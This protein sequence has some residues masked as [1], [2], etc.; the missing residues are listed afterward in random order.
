M[1]SLVPP[2][3]QHVFGDRPEGTPPLLVDSDETRRPEDDHRPVVQGVME[4][5]TGRDDP[6]DDR[7]R[8]AHRC[9]TSDEPQHAAR[10][11]SV[12]VE[13]IVD[14][15]MN[16]RN[17]DR[18]IVGDEPDV[19]DQR[20]I[21]DL[22]DRLSVVMA[23]FGMATDAS[24]VH[25]ARLPGMIVVAHAAPRCQTSTRRPYSSLDSMS[26]SWRPSAMIV[27]SATITTRSAR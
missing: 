25:R 16:R 11:R 27:P 18:V 15:G 13:N 5:R 21:E 24:T 23:P 19:T 17:H 8:H 2:A 22:I 10:R 20:L 7:G 12:Q 4:D 14:P 26:S 9:S 6:V 3:R 1:A